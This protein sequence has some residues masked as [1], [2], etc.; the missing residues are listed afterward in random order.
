MSVKTMK[1]KRPKKLFK[2]GWWLFSQD[3]THKIKHE[4]EEEYLWVCP[5]CNAV[6]EL[7]QAL[8]REGKATNGKPVFNRHVLYKYRDFPS[9]GKP[10]ALCPECEKIHELIEKE[11]NYEELNINDEQLESQTKTA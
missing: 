7:G 10:V 5:V 1:Q 4:K 11:D 6:W 2:N 3:D 8:F 9:I